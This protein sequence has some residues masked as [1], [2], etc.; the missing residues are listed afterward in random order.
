MRSAL[1]QVLEEKEWTYLI[2]G[3]VLMITSNAK[4]KRLPTVQQNR[5]GDLVLR[6][7]LP[8]EGRGSDD[9]GDRYSRIIENPFL[10]AAEYPLSTFSIDVDT[11]SFAKV[12]RYLLQEN[13]LPPPDAVR[14][15]ELINYFSYELPSPKASSRWRPDWKPQ[16]VP[17]SHSIDCC[18]SV[19]RPAK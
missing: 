11:A 4:A 3:K 15:E 6:S 16:H 7:Q 10:D 1:R 8:D 18:G 17:G 14:I 2:C 13:M 9:G 19:S 12:R 5:A